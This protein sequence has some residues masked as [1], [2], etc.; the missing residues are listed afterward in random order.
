MRYS[1]R[2]FS[3]GELTWLR[4]QIATEKELTRTI[5]SRRFCQKY[6]WVK[7]N[8]TFKDVSCRVALLRMEEDGLLTLPPRKMHVRPARF[9]IQRTLFGEPQPKRTFKAGAVSLCLEV[10][11]HRSSKLWNEFIDRYHY[12]GYQTLPGAQLRYF[13]LADGEIIACLGFGASAWKVG[14]RDQFIGWSARQ[15]EQNLGLIINNARFLILPWI[16]SY[17]LGSRILSLVHRSI[18]SDWEQLYHF[19]PV[20]LETFVE[21]QRFSG[22]VYKAANWLC[23]GETTGRGKKSRS[24]R[25]EK[26]IKSIWLFPLQK[27]FR[28][29]LCGEHHEE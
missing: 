26:P 9:S 29:V 19:R 12:L 28:S 5:L 13:V 17:N 23:V 27:N 1:G 2:D 22:T 21:K 4:D 6:G 16:H 3:E 7:A 10:V 14:P 25:Q 11:D 20:L 18:A 24:K 15:R 8:G